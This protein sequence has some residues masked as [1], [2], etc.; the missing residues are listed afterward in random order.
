MKRITNI[1]VFTIIITTFFNCGSAFITKNSDEWSEYEL[2]PSKLTYDG[3]I[4]Y[5][6]R[7]S[8]KTSFGVFWD[9]VV[10]KDG[11]FYYKILMQDFGWH[12]NT[13]GGWS[14]NL[15]SIRR[16]KFGYIYVNPK[17]KVAV[18]FNPSNEKYSA[19]KVKFIQ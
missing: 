14:G 16:E 5:Y 9:K 4:F 15:N 6:G 19:F 18:Y 3:E 11:E 2:R 7:L 13:K 8:D 12:R 1:L 17:R 10:E